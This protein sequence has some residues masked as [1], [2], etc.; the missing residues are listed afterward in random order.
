M[1]FFA[2]AEDYSHTHENESEKCDCRADHYASSRENVGVERL[3]S[4]A[5]AKHQQEAGQ[6]HKAGYRHEDEVNLGQ[7]KAAARLCLY[8]VAGVFVGSCF[9]VCCHM[10][11]CIILSL[12][13][14][15]VVVVGAQVLV[16]GK[17]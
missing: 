2:R 4:G 14:K 5:S 6:D 17:Q 8:Y 1:L 16:C 3:D 13:F 12:S 9:V 7:G 15:H 10:S 11:G